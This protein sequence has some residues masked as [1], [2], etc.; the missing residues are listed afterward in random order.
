[1]SARRRTKVVSLRSAHAIRFQRALDQ[2]PN[3]PA[4]IRRQMVEHVQST[5]DLFALLERKLEELAREIEA[6]RAA[7]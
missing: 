5:V 6:R 1:M 2:L 4:D 7:R 3:L